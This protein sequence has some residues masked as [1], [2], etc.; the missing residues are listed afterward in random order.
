MEDQQYWSR[1]NSAVSR[2]CLSETKEM[3]SSGN[4]LVNSAVGSELE[5]CGSQTLLFMTADL[6]MSH[7]KITELESSI[8]A[9]QTRL[10]HEDQAATLLRKQLKEISSA[11]EDTA[12]TLQEKLTRV[13]AQNDTLLEVNMTQQMKLKDLGSAGATAE[14]VQRLEE[15]VM[16]GRRRIQALEA[17]LATQRDVHVYAPVEKMAEYQDYGDF[18]RL[19]KENLSHNHN[20][21]SHRML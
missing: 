2:F 15:S 14:E 9:L 11:S 18:G 5:W 20:P 4:A 7:N 19:S 13:N 10:I 1:L 17:Q 16:E 8:Q 21:Q 12:W 3:Q 6:F